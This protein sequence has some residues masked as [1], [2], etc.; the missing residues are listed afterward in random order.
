VLPLAS[1]ASR[2][3]LFRHQPPFS[4]RSHAGSLSFHSTLSVLLSRF[5][6]EPTVSGILFGSPHGHWPRPAS[7]EARGKPF[8]FL[9]LAGLISLFLQS[10]PI[11]TLPIGTVEQNLAFPE[12]S[13]GTGPGSHHPRKAWVRLFTQKLYKDAF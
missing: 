7:E 13:P 8:A 9:L 6:P 5:Y 3:L 12:E 10:L 11:V 4:S 2:L 1:Q